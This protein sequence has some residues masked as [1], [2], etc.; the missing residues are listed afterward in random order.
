MR[1]RFPKAV[2]P[3]V[4]GLSRGTPSVHEKRSK[5]LAHLLAQKI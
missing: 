2:Q 5:D 4:E 1:I 3:E